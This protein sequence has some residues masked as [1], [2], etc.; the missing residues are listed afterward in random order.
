MN[1]YFNPASLIAFII[2]LLPVGIDIFKEAF[3]N[4]MRGDLLNEFTLMIGASIGA[5]AIGEYP[6]AVAVLLFY[7]LGERL[8]DRAS[9]DVRRRIKSLLGRM[10]Q[11][12]RMEQDGLVVNVKPKDVKP[13]SVIIVRP[14]ERTPIDGTLWGNR[15][16]EFDTSAI[17]GESVPRTFRPGQEILSGMIPIDRDVR[18]TT[19]KP[20]ADSS[21]SRIMKMIDEA[22]AR[23]APTE[24][25]LRRI[26]RWYTPAVFILAF[27]LFSVPWIIALCGGPGFE[28]QLWLRRSLVFLVCSCPCA[29]VVSIPL[30]YFASIGTAGRHGLLFKGS[31]YL[32][33][34]R[35]ITTVALDKTGTI[36]TGKFQVHDIAL[37]PGADEN[38]LSADDILSIAAA[39]DAESAH[40]LAEAIRQEATARGL[41]IN[42]AEDVVTV[43][44]GITGN[45]NGMNVAVGSPTLMSR[46][47]VNSLDC[48]PADSEGY[49]LIYVAREGKC[50]GVILLAD[51]IKPEAVRAVGRLH[52]EGVKK[53]V[54]LSGDRKESV[55]RVAEVIGADS[56]EGSLLPEDK[57]RIIEG[58][59]SRGE[60]VLFAG[61]GI[62]DA[63]AIAGADIGVAMGAMG[64]DMAMETA[65]IV[66]AGDNLERLPDAIALARRVRHVVIENISFALGIKILVMT[67]GAF[68]IA[69]L[70][71]AVFA[72]TGV[73][74]VTIIWTLLRLRK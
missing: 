25:M 9:G 27:L 37:S 30:S 65:D 39:V 3:E 58:M 28:W 45:I 68:G 11:E 52:R 62:N 48:L 44:H 24:T 5:F 67:L 50:L 6:E 47:G 63:P 46:I 12:A 22:S 53:I 32:D 60:H 19:T 70:W 36:T 17:T 57:N 42:R 18:L 33:T 23:K 73:T 61:D 7:S 4:W 1:A 40:P 10:P 26:T 69:T 13:G 14:G 8:E 41:K 49:T 72:D 64:T 16:I 59:K 74:A 35:N 55:A 71:A 15:E 2:A 29:L 38:H 54:V 31:N 56:Y 21:M 34:L 20:F 66:V 51:G 43:P